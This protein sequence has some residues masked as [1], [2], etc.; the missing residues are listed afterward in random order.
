M[1]EKTVILLAFSACI[2]ALHAVEIP[3]GQL[4]LIA[5]DGH[6]Q[7]ATHGYSEVIAVD[8]RKV[9]FA[10]MSGGEKFESKAWS[11]DLTDFSMTGPVDLDG[12]D[13]DPH[14]YPNLTLD[15]LGRLHVVY[16]CHSNPMYY[17]HLKKASD[18]SAWTPVRELM[19]NATYPRIF[20]RENGNLV[21][22]YRDLSDGNHYGYIES[23][24]N[25][26]TWSPFRALLRGGEG[27]TSVAYV[28]G[29]FLKGDA[30][31]IAWSWYHRA[32]PPYH[33]D[34]LS[35]ARFGFTA[36]HGW[37]AGGQRHKLPLEPSFPK[38]AAGIKQYAKGVTLDALGRPVVLYC[39]HDDT[40]D[41]GVKLATWDGGRWQFEIPD[42]ELD[43]FNQRFADNP[44]GQVTICSAKGKEVVLLQKKRDGRWATRTVAEC[45]DVVHPVVLADT[46]RDRY[47]IFFHDGKGN[48]YYTWSQKLDLVVSSM[49]EGGQVESMSCWRRMAC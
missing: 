29:V 17:R 21:V 28:G 4:H 19:T 10:Y 37:Q 6:A 47:H 20:T 9:Y 18:V 49:A 11:Y 31:H 8:S 14:N 43:R 34:D 30:I 13:Q 42:G 23:I 36:D 16:G 46:V 24:D 48:V 27:W 41:D 25:G 7:Y 33:Y 40:A 15:R 12:R 5:S 1:A 26:A 38:V 32:E 44:K 39:D 22:F 35:Y 3:E 45:S 2:P